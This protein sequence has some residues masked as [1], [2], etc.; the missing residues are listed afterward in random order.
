MDV[1]RLRPVGRTSLWIGPLGMGGAPLGAPTLDDDVAVATVRAA[2]ASGVR[3]LDTAPLYGQGVSERRFGRALMGVPRDSFVLATKVGRWLPVDAAPSSEPLPFDYSYDG[4]MRTV[5]ASLT[6]LGLDRVDILHVHDP[7]DHEQAAIDGA[8]RALQTLKEQGVCQAIGS[9]M[10]QAEMLT[11]FARAVPV[12]C[13]LLAGRY[14]L[15]DQIGLRELLPLCVERGISIIIG[16]PYNS[17]ILA[18]GARPGATYNYAPAPAE[19]L[20]TTRQLEAICDR[21][22]VPLRAAA[23]QFSLAHPA[24][25]AVIPGAQSVAEAEDNLRMV[26]WPV[27]PDFWHELRASTLVDPVAP[28]PGDA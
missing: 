5:E 26:S 2:L 25:V 22:A 15:L 3:L 28:L 27:P 17:G 1:Q 11:R 19:L 23:L 10:N 7:D 16:G 24:V 4:V 12:D 14:T 18:I 9:G 20:E 6:R 21:H 13:F 8:F